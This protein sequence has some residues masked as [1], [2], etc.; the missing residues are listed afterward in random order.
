MKKIWRGASG[1]A[2]VGTILALGAGVA[3]AGTS[4]SSYNTTVGA[5]NGNG[6]TG[7]QTKATAAATG[8]LKSAVVGGSYTLTAWMQ[9]TG[10]QDQQQVNYIDD[11]TTYNLPNNVAKGVTVRVHFRN[12]LVT[13]VDVQTSGTW[14][15]N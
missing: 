3:M 5:W 12:G 15:S 10:G 6:Y 11:N 14:R 9:T 8:T 2:A 4:Y 1:V 13:P 7:S